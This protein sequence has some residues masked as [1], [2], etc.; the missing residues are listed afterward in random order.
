MGRIYLDENGKPYDYLSVRN[1]KYPLSP[2]AIFAPLLLYIPCAT[3][4]I[5]VD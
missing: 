4:T 5:S 1:P 2:Y 3:R